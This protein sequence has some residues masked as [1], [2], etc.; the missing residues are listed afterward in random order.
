MEVPQ[1]GELI[2]AEK[3][4]FRQWFLFGQ[5]ELRLGLAQHPRT[6]EGSAGRSKF[7]G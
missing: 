5:V 2:G 4:N 7:T 1:I 6:L 3:T